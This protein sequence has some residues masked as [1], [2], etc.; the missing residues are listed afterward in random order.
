MASSESWEHIGIS[1]FLENVSEWN[2]KQH[3]LK[4]NDWTRNKFLEEISEASIPDTH[5]DHQTHTHH[6]MR[7][8]T[9]QT[10]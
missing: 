7:K 3:V 2:N 4:I 6:M 8:Q 5:F 1:A 9:A 10:N